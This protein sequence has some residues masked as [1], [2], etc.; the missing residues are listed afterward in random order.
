MW[1]G[2]EMKS[3]LVSQSQDYAYE[4]QDQTRINKKSACVSV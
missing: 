2:K 4:E 3:P 1:P